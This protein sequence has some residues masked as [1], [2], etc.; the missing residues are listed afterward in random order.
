MSQSTH[1]AI[2]HCRDACGGT[3]AL[4]RSGQTD[5]WVKSG[6][7]RGLAAAASANRSSFMVAEARFGQQANAIIPFN[8]E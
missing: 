5:S 7:R 3:R 1:P 4:R 6:K 8:F 2:G